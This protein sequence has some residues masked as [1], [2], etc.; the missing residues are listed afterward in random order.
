MKRHVPEV[1]EDVRERSRLPGTWRERRVQAR[2]GVN[3]NLAESAH[4]A[5]ASSVWAHNEE[6]HGGCLVSSRESTPP[7]TRCTGGTQRAA[8]L[9]QGVALRRSPWRRGVPAIVRRPSPSRSARA[10]ARCRARCRARRRSRGRSARAR[11]DGP[12][13]ARGRRARPRRRRARPCG[14]SGRPI[15]TAYQHREDQ[16][17]SRNRLHGRAPLVHDDGAVGANEPDL[18]CELLPRELRRPLLGVKS[19]R[20]PRGPDRPADQ[21]GAPVAEKAQQRTVHLDD[22]ATL[23]GEEHG[24]ARLREGRLEEAGPARLCHAPIVVD[25]PIA[26]L[27]Y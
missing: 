7:Y 20:L 15:A 14:G 26:Q 11:R 16:L 17:A 19:A 5:Q 22:A 27:R 6:P 8:F 25:R 1:Q 24:V 21:V 12:P 2:N 3:V 9:A 4:N 18:A 13:R 23:V 10:C